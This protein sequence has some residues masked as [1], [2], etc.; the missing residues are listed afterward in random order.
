MSLDPKKSV[1]KHIELSGTQKDFDALA[2]VIRQA[3]K[4]LNVDLLPG[5]LDIPGR[6]LLPKGKA[7]QWEYKKLN[8]ALGEFA[9]GLTE[10][11][12]AVVDFGKTRITDK[13]E[14]LIKDSPS[15]RKMNQH[16]LGIHLGAGDIF[17]EDIVADLQTMLD[18]R[19]QL[20]RQAPLESIVPAWV[21]ASD[22]LLHKGKVPIGTFVKDKKMLEKIDEYPPDLAGSKSWAGRK[23]E[24]Y[25]QAYFAILRVDKLYPMEMELKTKS[26]MWNKWIASRPVPD[27]MKLYKDQPPKNFGQLLERFAVY[28]AARAFGMKDAYL[29][30]VFAGTNIDKRVGSKEHYAD[31]ILTS[32][33]IKSKTGDKHKS[34]YATYMA[35]VVVG[36]G[37]T[38]TVDMGR[39][40][41]D[42]AVELPGWD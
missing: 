8:K 41:I 3:V 25:N 22:I 37:P 9:D 34:E 32:E 26:G 18:P 29:A 11:G 39:E 28:S 17:K 1:T 31:K 33:A 23:K 14:E 19:T 12:D 2:D 42:S 20:G 13:P 30:P 5:D 36:K 27:M 15:L 24:G 7:T 16:A 6:I 35:F 10:E 4:K 38:T 40:K 21:Y